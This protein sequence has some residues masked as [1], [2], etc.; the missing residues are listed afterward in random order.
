MQC[1]TLVCHNGRKG[2][3][4]AAGGLGEQGRKDPTSQNYEGRMVEHR[5]HTTPCSLPSWLGSKGLPLGDGSRKPIEVGT[6]APK[7]GDAGSRSCSHRRAPGLDV[8]IAFQVWRPR[9]TVPHP[10]KD[11][12]LLPA[13]WRSASRRP[14]VGVG[15]SVPL[16]SGASRSLCRWRPGAA[17]H[18]PRGQPRAR[19][20]LAGFGAEGC[21]GDWLAPDGNL[22]G[23][24]S[25]WP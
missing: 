2:S 1:A 5:I 13:T 17:I 19:F 6:D 21:L 3:K 8:E 24:L 15:R 9:M 23:D 7:G 14:T 10:P 11:G 16:T 22:R 18:A 12:L 20:E 4:K 25:E